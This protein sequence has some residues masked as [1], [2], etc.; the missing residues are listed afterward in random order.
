MAT[1]V[2][3]QQQQHPPARPPLGL[4]HPLRLLLVED[5]P[6]NQ[7]A[8]VNQLDLLG[9][10]CDIAPDGLDVVRLLTP[11]PGVCP[12]DVVL[13]DLCLQ[14]MDGFETMEWLRQKYPLREQRPH[15]I[16]LT[17]SDR[18]EEF[19][20]CLRLGIDQYIAKPPRMA[21]IVMALE[22]AQPLVRDN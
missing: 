5:E 15:V 3:A 22:R 12:Y 9:Y 4:L 17:W 20:R 2:M 21:D 1:A 14:H 6:A 8:L 10:R 7:A 13:L 18:R 16:V 11:H 19:M